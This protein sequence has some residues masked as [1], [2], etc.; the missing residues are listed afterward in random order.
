MEYNIKSEEVSVSFSPVF[1]VI[2]RE[3]ETPNQGVIKRFVVDH[4]PVVSVLIYNPKKLSFYMGKEY[5]SG[6]NEVRYGNPAGY[7]DSGETP[8]EAA[9]REVKEE[10]GICVDPNFLSKVKTISSSEG[11]TNE[12]VHIFYYE[13]SDISVGE[14]SFDDDEYIELVEI[15][16]LEVIEMLN[17]N[18]LL[19]GAPT[20]LS[21]YWFLSGLGGDRY[22][23]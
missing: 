9:I 20:V 14:T 10:L 8:E 19:K 12:E 23:V 11:F 21:L 4:A 18:T 13:S 1:D 16:A 6:V 2:T 22:N 17:E 3:I 15:P 5:R 7:I